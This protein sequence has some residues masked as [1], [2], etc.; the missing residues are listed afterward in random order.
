MALNMTQDFSLVLLS[1][2]PLHGCSHMVPPTRNSLYL[3]NSHGCCCDLN[4]YG[5]HKVMCL[6]VWP[7]GC[8]TIRRCGLVGGVSVGAGFDVSY[9]QATP[10]VAHSLLIPEELSA[11]SVCLSCL[12]G[13]CHASYHDDNGLNLRTCKP[14]P[15]KCFPF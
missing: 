1:P 12:P 10:S 4:R 14:A 5:P 11:Q 3:C 9:A 15:I 2:S 7:I 8:G 6:T 13:C